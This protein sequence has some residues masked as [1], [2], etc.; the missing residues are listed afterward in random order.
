MAVAALRSRLLEQADDGQLAD[1]AGQDVVTAADA[2]RAGVDADTAFV[3]PRACGSV[4][5]SGQDQRD[6]DTPVSAG[7]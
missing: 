4:T 3:I 1:L 6:S 2:R 7:S 5:G